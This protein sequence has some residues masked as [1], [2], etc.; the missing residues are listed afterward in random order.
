MEIVQIALQVILGL[1]FLAAGLTK[2]VASK[3][4]LQPK[5]AWVNSFPAAAVKGIGAAEALGGLAL[6]LPL[7]SPLTSVLALIAAFCLAV[8]MVL[9]IVV[10]IRLKEANQSVPAGVLLVMLAVLI[11]LLIAQ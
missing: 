5:M 9:A 4:T 7:V 3:A 10:H 6:L 2:V 1:I 11:A 8:T